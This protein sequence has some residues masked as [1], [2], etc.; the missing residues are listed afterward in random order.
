MVLISIIIY[1]IIIAITLILTY[2]YYHNRKLMRQTEHPSQRLIDI[3]NRQSYQLEVWISI[4]V[5]SSI[6]IMLIILLSIAI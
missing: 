3:V 4:L 5:I 2:N 1:L 6:V